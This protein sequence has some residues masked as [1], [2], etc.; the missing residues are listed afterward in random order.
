MHLAI[1]MTNTDESEFS[2][3]HPKDGQKFTDLIHGV[4][5]DW[6]LSVFS[7][8][9]GHFPEDIAAFSGAMI[10]GSPAS[11]RSSRPWVPP[12]LNLIRDMHARKQPLFGACFG[13]QAI[14][15][16]LGGEIDNNPA[17]W[18]H[19]TIRNQSFF[20]PPWAQ[21]LPAAFHLY[22]SHNEFVS[23]LPDGAVQTASCDGL[24]AGFA[25]AQHIW[26]TQHHPE[27]S[28]EFITALT[29]EMRATLP[30]AVYEAAVKSLHNHADQ[31]VFAEALA[32]FFEQGQQNA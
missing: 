31:A 6:E 9:D 23:R 13:H 2:E 7:V 1:L 22:G 5:P 17:G 20:A 25:I 24:L 12:L 10:T 15:R 8:K 19:G 29:E 28:H 27:M 16:A 26:T 21:G 18:V 30:K 4:R 32:R 3:R 14:A 11:V